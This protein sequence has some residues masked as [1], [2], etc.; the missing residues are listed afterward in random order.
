MALPTQATPHTAQDWTRIE[1]RVVAE[2]LV[3]EDAFSQRL[4]R[5]AWRRGVAAARGLLRL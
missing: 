4:A 1:R 3:E 5:D 2:T